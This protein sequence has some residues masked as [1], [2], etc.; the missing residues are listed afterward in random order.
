MNNLI[1]ESPRSPRKDPQIQDGGGTA[2]HTPDN[3]YVFDNGQFRSV[4]TGELYQPHYNGRLFSPGQAE[5]IA[6]LSTLR[7]SPSPPTLQSLTPVITAAQL[8]ELI[9]Q[10]TH[11]I[12]RNN[13]ETTATEE[14][15]FSIAKSEHYIS[16]GLTYKFDGDHEKLAPWIKKFKALRTNAL[17]RDATYLTVNDVRYDILADFT[18]IKESS[19]K[20]QAKTAGRQ[21]IRPKASSQII[22]PT[23]THAF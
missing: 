13:A 20:A 22:L 10:L 16:Q 14:H 2:P 21:I 4:I 1:D 7:A 18:K 6:A 23:F 8:Q 5:G 12:K 19:I 3:Q 17:W 11:T 9:T 15:L